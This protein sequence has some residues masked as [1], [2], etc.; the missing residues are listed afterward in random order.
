ME[1]LELTKS[2]LIEL[3]RIAT[4]HLD[5]RLVPYSREN[6]RAM[7]WIEGFYFVK[8][9]QQADEEEKAKEEQ[10]TSPSP[11]RI[12]EIL[13]NV[14][15][16]MLNYWLLCTEDYGPFHKGERYWLELLESGRVCGRSDNMKGEK[17]DITLVE[18]LSC[19]E[20]TDDK[21]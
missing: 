3:A 13:R 7:A 14:V 2:E 21:V 19:F 12:Q 10:A 6:L 20:V 5:D 18:L 4:F 15:C 8:R 1:K 9:H 16:E 11:C 17:T